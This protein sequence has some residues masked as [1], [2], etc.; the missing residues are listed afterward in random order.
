LSAAIFPGRTGLDGLERIALGFGCSLAIVPLVALIIEY[1]PWRLE[2]EPIVIGLL[3]VTVLGSAIAVTRRTLLSPEERYKI[4][5]SV[6][7]LPP[8]NAWDGTTR[9]L[10]VTAAV[11]LVLFGWSGVAI[12]AA[13]FQDDPRTEFALFSS[14]G[15]AAYYPRVL[16]AGAPFEIKL[17]ITNREGEAAD[18]QVRI[19]AGQELL[20]TLDVHLADGATWAEV[21]AITSPSQVL[22]ETA[23]T[24]ELYRVSPTADEQPYRELRLMVSSRAPSAGTANAP[25][26]EPA[27]PAPPSSAPAALP[28]PAPAV[29]PTAPLRQVGELVGV[30]N[31]ETLLVRVDNAL[32]TVSLLGVD[33]PTAAGECY[34]PETQAHLRGLLERA[35]GSLIL[36]RDPNAPDA[37]EAAAI[38][39]YV[40]LAHPDGLRLLNEELIK[41]GYA[42]H[43]TGEPAYTYAPLFA[44]KQQA[45]EGQG[46]G[47]WSACQGPTTPA[48]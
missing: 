29:P 48:P 26:A 8:P 46:L 21:A 33:A 6:P 41:W 27:A 10:V 25:A 22:G 34:A 18:F 5:V 43:A 9:A 44:A 17:E 15:E 28:T 36:M 39:R 12:L 24:F 4:T 20:D 7:A 37:G 13:R 42:R 11:A 3:T 23:L 31:N 32:L 2:L 35:G 1:S 45:A 40:W 30:F 16:E 14:S 19:L 47:L 38:Y